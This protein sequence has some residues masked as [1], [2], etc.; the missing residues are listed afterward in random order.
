MSFVNFIYE[1]EL[2]EES[3]GEGS[4]IKGK[5]H[6]ILTGYH[7][8]NGKHMT[9]HPDIDGDSPKQAHDK[10]KAKVL[11]QENGK[12][13]YKKIYNRAKSTAEDL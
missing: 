4:D 3:T 9:K 13:T 12:E 1:Q 7:L 11:A 5:L 8:L 10:L 2:L 6:E